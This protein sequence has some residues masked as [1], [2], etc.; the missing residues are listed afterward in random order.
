MAV[1]YS[2]TL[3]KEDTVLGRPHTYCRYSVNISHSR[4]ALFLKLCKSYIYNSL[5]PRPQNEIFSAYVIKFSSTKTSF[6]SFFIFSEFT[7]KIKFTIDLFAVKGSNLVGS[8]LMTA[9]FL[10]QEVRYSALRQSSLCIYY[11]NSSY[12]LVALSFC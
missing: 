3:A 9:Q 1:R 2:P 4:V 12:F 8:H 10:V 7:F 11:Y 6:Q 5:N